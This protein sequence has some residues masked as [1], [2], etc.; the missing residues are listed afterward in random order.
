MQVQVQVHPQAT[1]AD[2]AALLS[3]YGDVQKVSKVVTLSEF[4]PHAVAHVTFGPES[5]GQ[6]RI[7]L[8]SRC[9]LLDD[10]QVM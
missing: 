7:G 9:C 2:I 3:S 10:L 8:Y 6:V 5:N 1:E 4:G